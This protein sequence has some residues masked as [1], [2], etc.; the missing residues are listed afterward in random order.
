ME[1]KYNRVHGTRDRDPA[2][3]AITSRKHLRN[4]NKEKIEKRQA[5]HNI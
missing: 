3:E 2:G 5:Q 1:T 4:E